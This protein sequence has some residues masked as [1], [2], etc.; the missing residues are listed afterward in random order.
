M[1]APEQPQVARTAAPPPLTPRASRLPPALRTALQ[2]ASGLAALG[3]GGWMWKTIVAY[4]PGIS[5]SALMLIS[6]LTGLLALP[7]PLALRALRA[8]R[9]GTALW[10][11]ALAPGLMFAV[12]LPVFLATEG[13]GPG[14]SL[15]VLWAMA[16][17][18]AALL[19]WLGLRPYRWLAPPERR[20]AAGGEDT[21]EAVPQAGPLL[22]LAMIASGLLW[23][24]TAAWFWMRF[25]L[26]SDG[27]VDAIG[28]MIALPPLIGMLPLAA[29]LLHARRW[30][31]A[32]CVLMLLPLALL[33]QFAAIMVVDT[34]LSSAGGSGALGTALGIITE[35]ALAAG[36]LVLGLWIYRHP[37]RR[38]SA[39]QQSAP[40]SQWR[41]GLGLLTLFL[42]VLA[43]GTGILGNQI[44]SEQR[45]SVRVR[46]SELILA[47]TSARIA[48]S[49]G[50]Q[51]TGSWSA[52]WM[53]SITISATGLIAS[54][55]V[56]PTGQIIVH[57]TAPT[58]YA[59]ITMTPS[60][61]TDNKLV[62]S[63]TGQPAKYMPA[64]C[65]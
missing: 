12:Q 65:R 32:L 24:Y 43:L 23:P 22:I 30:P 53:S 5:E 28:L 31:A 18:S 63:C 51:T 61:T 60:T 7:G 40:T 46:V 14:P 50:M 38:A 52:L 25:T 19:L 27:P 41:R 17:G 11:V 47:A 26:A 10:I 15:P 39:A 56:G 45:S 37:T 8:R 44:E 57:G 49:E 36:W 54:A 33:A 13:S 58:S 64:S 42:I 21:V 34:L 6:A 29:L 35:A 59:S 2:I 62:W 20:E 9:Y 16:A 3:C 4:L 55:S 48:L 1:P